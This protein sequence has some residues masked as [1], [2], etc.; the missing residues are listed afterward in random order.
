M[1][2]DTTG[3]DGA[4]SQPGQPR[5]A[6]TFNSGA[7]MAPVQTEEN[8]GLGLAAKWGAQA[9]HEVKC[10]GKRIFV[11]ILAIACATATAVSTASVSAGVCVYV[12]GT[13][14]AARGMGVTPEWLVPAGTG[15]VQTALLALFGFA[16][17]QAI[18]WGGLQAWVQRLIQ[19]RFAMGGEWAMLIFILPMAIYLFG[20]TPMLLLAGSFAAVGVA[21]AL[22]T[23][24][25][26]RRRAAFAKA[27]ELRLRPREPEKVAQYRASLAEFRAKVAALPKTARSTGESIAS[28]ADNILACMVSDPRDLEP[29]H[30]FLNRYFKAAHTVVDKHIALAREKVI[31]PDIADALAKSEET[32]TRLDE[33]FAKE[34]ERLLQN[35][36]T[37]F[38]ADLAVIDTLLKMDGR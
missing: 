15:L 25:V 24:A 5:K 28:G 23:Q 11:H 21:G 4:S 22:V 26:F 20:H 18:F 1:R 8:P 38:S 7:P 10:L 2:D 14:L 31:T 34:H 36:V 9:L 16:F 29:G 19:K 17:P 37:D 27:E 32:L 12:G 35:D 30:R 6:E 13:C 33:V 3:K